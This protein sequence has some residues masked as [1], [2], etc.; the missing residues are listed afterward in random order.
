MKLGYKHKVLI[1]GVARTHQ[2]GVPKSVIQIIIKNK[3]EENLARGTVKVAVLKEDDELPDLI[4]CSLYDTK[5]VYFLL[6]CAEEVFW[7][8]KTQNV[9]DKSTKEKV[10][11]EF[12]RLNFV[13]DYNYGIVGVDIAD[14]LRLQ[15]RVDRWMRQ[16]KWW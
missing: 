16:H 7:V 11:I 3:T 1:H 13:E 2:R 5:P 15:Y 8:L 6:T 12:L 4:S 9:F 14:Q 10:T